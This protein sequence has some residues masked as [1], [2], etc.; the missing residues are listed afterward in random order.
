MLV[1]KTRFQLVAFVIISIVAI[2]YALNPLDGTLPVPG[3]TGGVGG[4]PANQPP[5]LPL[6]G[7]L[8]LPLIGQQP[9]GQ[10]GAPRPTGAAGI[11]S[12]LSGGIG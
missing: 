6:P 1:R 5:P 12:L 9:G 2:V 11:L 4:A 8:S 10:G 3:L 7:Q